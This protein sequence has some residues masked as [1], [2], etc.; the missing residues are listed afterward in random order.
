MPAPRG[1]RVRF[2]GDPVRAVLGK[3]HQTDQ[4]SVLSRAAANGVGFVYD[5]AQRDKY[6]RYSIEVLDHTG[7]NVP[8][9]LRVAGGERF[10]AKYLEKLNY[11]LE[12]PLNQQAE[13]TIMIVDDQGQQAGSLT[14]VY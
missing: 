4:C 13:Y 11:R 10:Y 8:G 2:A 3:G 6:E 12:E 5:H 14:V 7:R 1:H 9:T